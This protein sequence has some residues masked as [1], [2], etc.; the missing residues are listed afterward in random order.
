MYNVG[1]EL[2][3][4]FSLHSEKKKKENKC[5]V[6]PEML[7][8]ICVVF[9]KPVVDSTSHIFT[10]TNNRCFSGC[11][12]LIV[13]RISNQQWGSRKNV[14][15]FYLILFLNYFYTFADDADADADAAEAAMLHC[16]IL[17]SLW[18]HTQICEIQ[19][20]SHVGQMESSP[21]TCWKERHVPR[22][23]GREDVVGEK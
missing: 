15:H 21:T 12:T 17:T 14:A 3:M 19:A 23:P 20:R 6:Q 7:H 11:C 4:K 5:F 2:I 22:W 16:S 18:A 10:H 8:A 9:H 13:S 1:D